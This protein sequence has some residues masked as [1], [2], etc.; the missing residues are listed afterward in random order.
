MSADIRQD[1]A[2][3]LQDMT[4]AMGVPL[5]AV[6]TETAD[7]FR[8]DL[9]GQGCEFLLWQRGEPLK[10][11]QHIVSTAFR[12]QL[13]EERRIVVDCQHFRRDKDTELRQMAK[14]LADKARRTGAPQE[15]GPLNA[16]ERRIVHL[17]VAEEGAS[18]ESVGDAAVKT[19]IIS[20]K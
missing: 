17:A 10:A 6:V 16:Y 8:V 11:L 1:V 9:E 12:R 4:R 15:I 5:E 18:S 13:G 19:V 14:F 3:F 7:G 2:R 20:P